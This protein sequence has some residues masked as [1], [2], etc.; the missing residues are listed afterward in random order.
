MLTIIRTNSENTD[1]QKLVSLLDAELKFR[2]GDDHAFYAQFNKT[3]K[4]KYAL[5]AYQNNIPVAC[6]AIREFQ[7]S[8]DTMEVKRMYVTEKDR[9]KG[10][11][12]KVLAELEKWT[13]EL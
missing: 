4:I 6:G 9:G 2:D 3:N 13:S 5:V 8:A 10:I 11:A 1:F 7:D 12:T